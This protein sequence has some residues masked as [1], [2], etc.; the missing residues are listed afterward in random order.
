MQKKEAIPKKLRLR[1]YPYTYVRTAVMKSLLFNK[2]G[3]DKMLK[4][5][6]NE[7]AKFLQ[8]TSYK[9]EINELAT[10]YSGPD[11]LELALNRSLAYSFKKLMRI[12]PDELDIVIS[13]Y[14]KRK[15]IEDIK[16]IIRGKFTNADEKMIEN[17]LT[18][19]GT[20]SMGFLIMLAKKAN[21]EEVLKGNKLV[22]HSILAPGLKE[23]NEKNN[24]AAIE[25]LLDKWYYNRLLQF[26]KI[27]P[28]E[29]TLFRNF[30]NT[31]IEVMDT[32]TI[33][34]LKKMNYP[35]GEITGFLINR[36]GKAAALA[37][38]ENIEELA[39]LSGKTGY[40]EIIEKGMQEFREKNSLISLETG[41]YKHLL[42]HATL[43]LHQHPLSVE[44]ILGYMLAKDIEV[45]NLKLL[46]KGKQLG[47]SEE[48]IGKQL[49]Y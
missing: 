36:E 7:I 9:S 33:F 45:R 14:A 41:L 1:R 26:S 30:L 32:L 17:S 40:R 2:S 42:K 34:R 12:S 46:I 16:T 25:N 15:D 39:K 23:L 22:D 38:A 43:L 44:I 29:G 49:V 6:F 28:R 48:F 8:E 10:R 24:P 21:I 11:L 37:G 5:G 19:A 13:E 4:M 20:L 18:G 47:L 31:E 27:L 3:Y 35:K